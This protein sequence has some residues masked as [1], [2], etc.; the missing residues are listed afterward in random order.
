MNLD[1]KYAI[2]KNP[3]HE[4]NAAIKHCNSTSFVHR[5][6]Y[7]GLCSVPFVLGHTLFVILRHFS[8][9]TGQ[10]RPQ[11]AHTGQDWQWRVQQRRKAHWGLGGVPKH[12]VGLGVRLWYAPIK[13]SA[14]ATIGNGWFTRVHRCNIV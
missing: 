13:L 8:D 10:P 5:F 7:H 14:V 2:L 11:K 6:D 9:K 1:S 12:K 3:T 4:R